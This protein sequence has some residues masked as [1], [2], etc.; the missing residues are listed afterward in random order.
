MRS[1]FY[2]VPVVA[3]ALPFSTQADE[4]IV[5]DLIVDGSLCAGEDCVVD[6]EFGFETLRLQSP[7]PQSCVP[8]HQYLCQLSYSG[9]DDGDY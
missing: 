5:D 7:T 9:L 8:G 3:L 4:V 6:A 2:V 1:F